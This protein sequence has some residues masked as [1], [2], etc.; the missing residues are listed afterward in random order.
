MLKL[1]IVG[2]ISMLSAVAAL[3]LALNTRRSNNLA[4]RR[5]FDLVAP[6]GSAGAVGSEKP[7]MQLDAN[8][9]ELVRRIFGVGV[10]RR[11]GMRSGPLLILGI[12]CASAIC[13]WLVVDRAFG[14][15][16]WL[17]A[18]FGAVAFYFIPRFIL[19]RQQRRAERQFMEL[20][21]NGIDMMVRM[22]RAGMP[23]STAVRTI[24]ADS[25]APL[26]TVFGEIADQVGLGVPFE[27]AVE[28]AS[29]R[30]G[31]PDFRF[32]AV[33]LNVQHTTGGNLAATLENLSELIRKRRALRLKAAA[34]TAEVRMSAYVLGALPIVTMGALLL[35]RP[36]YV[37][38]LFYDRRGNYILAAAAILLMLAFLT[39]RQMVRRVTAA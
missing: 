29:E 32:L 37:V 12:A 22:L 4:L 6:A 5:H 18:S 31:L 21:P 27:N 25:P 23:V 8:V 13:A 3:A 15:S 28:S 26:S 1:Q 17:A 34:A 11:W 10:P 20:F 24:Q 35:F 9:N 36:E 7:Y 14:H 19:I 2:L 16:V 33:A 30:I 39:M 38:P